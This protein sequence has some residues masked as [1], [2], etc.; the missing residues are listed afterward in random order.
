MFLVL[1]RVTNHMAGAPPLAERNWY[2]NNYSIF[3]YTMLGCVTCR[4]GLIKAK[5]HVSCGSA[6]V[7]PPFA[8]GIEGVRL[9]FSPGEPLGFA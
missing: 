3:Y 4:V 9:L 5:L 7:S 1:Y 2:I 8:V 6:L